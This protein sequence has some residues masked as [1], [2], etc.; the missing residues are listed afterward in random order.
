[1]PSE[2]RPSVTVGVPERESPFS[3][4][5]KTVISLLKPTDVIGAS[6][7]TAAPW[8]ILAMA[9][10]L[11]SPIRPMRLVTWV[12]ALVTCGLLLFDASMASVSSWAA[13]E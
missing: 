5:S 10:S 2:S 7:C 6:S 12:E 11:E 13:K 9:A 4:A 1:M 3:S 8:P